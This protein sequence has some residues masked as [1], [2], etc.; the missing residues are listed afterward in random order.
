MWRSL[1]L[2]KFIEHG[3]F[4]LYLGHVQHQ[5]FLGGQ[6]VQEF[7]VVRPTDALFIVKGLGVPAHE[8]F[9]FFLGQGSPT[10]WI[11]GRSTETPQRF[12][13]NL[14]QFIAVGFVQGP[15]FLRLQRGEF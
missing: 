7:G 5:Y 11:F 9:C 4:E 3:L 12:A 13:V 10:I 1:A 8:F 2:A 15:K 6:Y 14:G